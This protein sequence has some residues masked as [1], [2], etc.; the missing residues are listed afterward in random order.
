MQSWIIVNLELRTSYVKRTYVFQKTGKQL[1][2]SIILQEQEP[3][4]AKNE[5]FVFKPLGSIN[6]FQD[7]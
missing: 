7:F 2:S 3:N 1:A 5:E 6:M 4:F